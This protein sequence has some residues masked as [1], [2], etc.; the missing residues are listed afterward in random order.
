MTLARVAADLTLTVRGPLSNQRFL[1]TRPHSTLAVDLPTARSTSSVG[2]DTE[3]KASPFATMDQG[4]SGAAPSQ[5][6]RAAQPQELNALRSTTTNSSVS[7]DFLLGDSTKAGNPVQELTAASSAGLAGA[8][9]A[10]STP[11][12]VR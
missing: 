11:T 4:Q 9:D 12:P 2:S 7:E 3:V 1:P 5:H 8:I 6:L 10:P